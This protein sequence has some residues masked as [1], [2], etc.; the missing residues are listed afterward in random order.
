MSTPR[1]SVL[2]PCFNHGAFLDE[3]IG[4]VLAQTFQDFEII[5]V[6]DGSTD[7][8]TAEQI[9]KCVAP[10]TRIFRIENRGLSGARNFA[11]SKAEGA[12]FCALDADDR[13]AP[14]WFEKAVARLDADAD[15]GFVSHWLRAFG[16]ETWEWT[17]QRC[18]LTDLLVNNM[19]NGAALVRREV[20]QAVGGFEESMRD[21]CEDWDFWLRVVEQGYRGAIIPEFLFEYR[22][23]ADSM[24]RVMSAGG[25]PLPLHDVIARHQRYY[26]EHIVEVTARKEDEV[27]DLR[28]EVIR[29]RK[30]RMLSLEPSIARGRE[31]L[32][33]ALAKID[34]VRPLIELRQDRDR[35]VSE[36]A[37]LESERRDLAVRLA[38]EQA[39]LAQ[40]QARLAQEQAR[41]A[42]EQTQ[43]EE[44]RTAMTA[45]IAGLDARLA[46]ATSACERLSAHVSHLD[47]QIADLHHSLSWRLTEPLRRLYAIV[48]RPQP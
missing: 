37:R 8:E 1:I 31:E 43:K 18:E 42:Q 41:L 34:R 23:R 25:Y 7:P 6:D 2:L 29:L 15:L 28:R 27:A 12:V 48:K 5:L 4:S 19:V 35:L 9:Q 44:Q 47:G 11:A 40:E 20:F 30:E 24:S 39:R 3:A 45:E 16:D 10:R 17:P 38:H 22:R 26:R 14:T 46:N 33:A 13:L 32:A 36:V 21:G